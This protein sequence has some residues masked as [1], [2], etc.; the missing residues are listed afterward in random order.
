M[1][2]RLAELMEPFLMNLMLNLTV[3]ESVSELVD[4]SNDSSRLVLGSRVVLGF[5]SR[6]GL[7]YFADFRV[8]LVGFHVNVDEG[9]IS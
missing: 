1:T 3:D 5:G 8:G 7:D 4:R 6:F 2:D 9:Y